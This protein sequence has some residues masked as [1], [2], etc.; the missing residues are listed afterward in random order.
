MELLLNNPM[1][2]ILVA[3]VCVLIG[4]YVWV[5][6]DDKVKDNTHF[7]QE[8]HNLQLSFVEKFGEQREQMRII[9]KTYL[10]KQTKSS[11]QKKWL[12]NKTEE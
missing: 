4:K 7:T 2:T 8:I 12:K 10:K 3:F 5:S 6:K 9:Q 1:T 11:S